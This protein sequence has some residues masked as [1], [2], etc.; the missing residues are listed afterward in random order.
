M[1]EADLLGGNYNGTTNN[2]Y[3]DN[4]TAYNFQTAFT[5]WVDTM[6]N[7]LHSF[8]P[9]HLVTLGYAGEPGP[10][11]NSKSVLDVLEVHN[12]NTGNS[13]SDENV[14]RYSVPSSAFGST[15]SSKPFLF[16]ELGNAEGA[17]LQCLD[18]D[19]YEDISFHNAEWATAFMGAGTGLYWTDWWEAEY[20][21]SYGGYQGNPLRHR[22]NFDALS[23]FF[24]D[25]NVLS[26][27]TNSS[28]SWSDLPNYYNIS[29]IDY[30]Y[31]SSSN[32]AAAI[33]WLHNST[34]SWDNI[35][36]P[37][38]SGCSYSTSTPDSYSLATLN[39]TAP[40]NSY[41]LSIFNTYTGEWLY[42]NIGLTASF[43]DI[44]STPLNF[45]SW[46]DTVDG[47]STPQSD[48]AFLLTLGPQTHAPVKKHPPKDSNSVASKINPSDSLALHVSN[49]VTN[50]QI[51][52]NFTNISENE[53][54]QTANIM[55][56]DML[57]QL[58]FSGK[59]QVLEGNKLLINLSAYA[60]G[61]YLVMVKTNN[62]ILQKKI[63]LEK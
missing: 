16:G 19:D 23:A 17:V 39:F 45:G 58:L 12:Y 10:Y 20:V 51:S 18:P 38:F 21:A 30:Y 28:Y 40:G 55:V 32:S 31:L 37:G 27:L 42:Q 54:N 41:Y 52:V 59:M 35:T 15:L 14:G 61:V 26:A 5:N 9:S 33:G 36:P 29:N 8:Y 43:L 24:N 34:V 53:L 57:G 11:D 44:A 25:P 49:T 7:Y 62:I 46:G 1:N 13:L 6:T 56:Y 60:N 63:I 4:S 22:H 48:Y 50:G 2:E 3:S 47:T